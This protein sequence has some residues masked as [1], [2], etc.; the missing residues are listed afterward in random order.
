MLKDKD[1]TQTYEDLSYPN[2]A[3][4]VCDPASLVANARLH[5]S[6]LGL[7]IKSLCASHMGDNFSNLRI[8]EIGCALGG[9]IIPL[10]AKYP[11]ME[12]VGVDLSVSQIEKAQQDAIALQL[13]NIEFYA[14]S[15]L[16]VE[17]E[18]V[19]FD[20]IIAH[21]VLSWVDRDTANAILARSGEL[22]KEQGLLYVSYNVLPGWYQEKA[23][24]DMMEFHIADTN[25][26]NAEIVKAREILSISAQLATD[27]HYQANLRDEQKIIQQ[28]PD[29][30][31]YHDYLETFN[32]PYYLKEVVQLAQQ[33]EFNYLGD[34]DLSSYS[35]SDQIHSF[36]YKQTHIGG[37]L[38]R[39]VI[40]E[41]YQDFLTNRRFRQSIFIKGKLEKST[42]DAPRIA[43][44]TFSFLLNAKTDQPLSRYE[45]LKA[46]H[47]CLIPQHNENSNI[48]KELQSELGVRIMALLLTEKLV[49][50]S[51][52]TLAERLSIQEPELNQ[53]LLSLLWDGLITPRVSVLTLSLDKYPCVWGVSRHY[54]KHNKTSVNLYHRNVHLDIASKRLLLL[55]DGLK[56]QRE[57]VDIM[58]SEMR[59]ASLKAEKIEDNYP[60]MLLGENIISY[61]AEDLKE[62][63]QFFVDDALIQF[64]KLGLL[65]E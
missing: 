5:I 41:Q 9:N 61:S 11:N 17:L 55:C 18:A 7:D 65:I 63:V 24:R 39:H 20:I 14:A 29:A 43:L 28:V 59:L 50:T 15:I 57:L 37:E 4:F 42:K 8:L 31:L 19:S 34:C 33:A 26:P 64:S 62:L 48:I 25:S 51:F 47:L 10:A 53:A 45:L 32:E 35:T 16:E 52:S 36:I 58:L 46:K 12:C 60:F 1:L 2:D 23:I 44:N 49:P 3:Y 54:A 6:R 40:D 27:K 56:T 13:N 21:G 22:L 38:P 30:Y